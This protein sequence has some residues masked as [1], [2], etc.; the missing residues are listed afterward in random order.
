VVTL[1]SVGDNAPY[2]DILKS[3]TVR[4]DEKSKGNRLNIR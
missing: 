4:R 3:I 2:I 1:D